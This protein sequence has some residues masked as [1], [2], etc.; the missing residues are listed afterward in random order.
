M[1]RI[2]HHK[3]CNRIRELFS[4][5]LDGRLGAREDALVEE[6]LSRCSD[7]RAEYDSL[8][9]TVD[10][11]AQVRPVPVP[12]SFVLTAVRPIPYPSFFRSLRIASIVFAAMLA[13][14][15]AGDVT[16]VLPGMLAHEDVSSSS[17]ATS[18]TPSSVPTEGDVITKVSDATGGAIGAGEILPPRKVGEEGPA[19]QGVEEDIKLP[20]D[21]SSDMTS[22]TPSPASQ[23]MPAELWWLRTLELIL[24]SIAIV[25]GGT[26]VFIWRRYKR[27]YS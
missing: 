19:P 23:T 5:H 17:S 18:A 2:F 10:L 7:C 1:L 4:E 16:K 3:K 8:R 22:T 26:T 20:S 21:S 27:I 12:R 13:L 11:L 6:H 15:F 9:K 14:V 24:L 25:V